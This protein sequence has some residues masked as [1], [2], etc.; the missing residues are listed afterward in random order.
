MISLAEARKAGRIKEFVEQESQRE[1]GRIDRA[2]FDGAVA[3]LVR[4]PQSEDRTSRSASGGNSS[5]KKTR[6]D[7]DL[8]A[9]N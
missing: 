6:R 8:D 9:S 4:A 1:I 3:E 5:E 7:T 2:E